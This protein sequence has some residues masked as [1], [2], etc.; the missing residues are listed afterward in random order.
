VY[1]NL[2]DEAILSFVNKIISKKQYFEDMVATWRTQE[3]LPMRL[4]PINSQPQEPVDPTPT[5]QPITTP[6][7]NLGKIAVFDIS[8][9]L[10]DP[11]PKVLK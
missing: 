4:C 10:W 2:A 5:Q 3:P 8:Q 6:K 9:R 11:F 1:A 7:L